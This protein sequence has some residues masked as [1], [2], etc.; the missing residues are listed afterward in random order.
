MSNPSPSLSLKFAFLLSLSLYT[1]TTTT[2]SSRLSFKSH[3]FP[4]PSLSK[5]KPKASAADLLS[6]L[7]TKQQASFVNPKVAEELKSCFKFI[8]PFSP[9]TQLL[10]ASRSNTRSLRRVLNSRP[11]CKPGL[12]E[13]EVDN[14]LVWFPPAPVMELARIAVDSGG[15]AGAIHR[16]LDPTIIPILTPSVGAVCGNDK[17]SK[18]LVL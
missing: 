18:A 8:V 5:P 16:A 2:S 4:S 15:D 10:C 12:R 13:E 11:E 1:T 17:L 3:S 6:L 7:G 14:N 9:P